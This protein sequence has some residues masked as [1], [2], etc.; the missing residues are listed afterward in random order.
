[1]PE[2]KIASFSGQRHPLHVVRPPTSTR[3]L[4]LRLDQLHVMVDDGFNK[5]DILPFFKA[6]A[7]PVLRHYGHRFQAVSKSTPR[8]D[9]LVEA[10]SAVLFEERLFRAVLDRLPEWAQQAIR[11]VIHYGPHSV[12]Q[13][14]AQ[15]G[16]PVM[17]VVPGRY[18]ASARLRTEVGMLMQDAD[19]YSRSYPRQLWQTPLYLPDAVRAH[20]KAILPP[21]LLLPEVVVPPPEHRLYTGS[22][23]ALG[24]ALLFMNQGHMAYTQ[25]GKP[26]RA[27]VRALHKTCAI[28]EFF[29]DTKGPLSFLATEHVIDALRGTSLP[30]DLGY[31]PA[32]LVAQ[33]LNIEYVAKRAYA[34]AQAHLPHLGNVE[35]YYVR[36][37]EHTA[38]RHLLG[39]L[40]ALRTDTWLAIEDLVRYVRYEGLDVVPFTAKE[41]MNM[42]S[43][44][45]SVKSEP[46]PD[47]LRDKRSY[48]YYYGDTISRDAYVALAHRPLLRNVMAR[49]AVLGVTEVA[50]TA[51]QNDVATVSGKPYL[52]VF[53]GV[54]HVRLTPLGAY[55][56]GH[57][58]TL[59]EAA[60]ERA[61]STVTLDPHYLILTIDGDDPLKNMVAEQMGDCLSPG[62]YRIDYAPFL[63]DCRRRVDVEDKIERF[64]RH[65]A[66]DVP[67]R[68]ATFFEEVVRKV[69][70]L[71]P[72]AAYLVFQLEV[73]G[74]RLERLHFAHDLLE[75]RSPALGHVAGEV[76]LEALDLV[77]HVYTA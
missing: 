56:V 3:G 73:G 41:V 58:D 32:D 42:V 55:L 25:A 72:Q 43:N 10:F 15:V 66:R 67:E 18:Q 4:P 37:A 47:A 22:P 75:E 64:K 57:T 62:R 16:E 48:Y 53:D 50:Y 63:R 24:R 44:K 68:W 31:T 65:L 38:R 30:D 51:P 21:P 9:E 69:Q 59:E 40:T 27:N 71:K 2:Q 11:Q 39:L 26:R 76:A 23:E 45:V 19:S 7:A 52:T 5:N 36:S 60:V 20:L 54:S 33:L 49:L 70:P 1:M 29:P 46:M 28:D 14:S 8:K 34:L 13:L 74:L 35:H 17:E 77:L 61:S 6:H 12:R